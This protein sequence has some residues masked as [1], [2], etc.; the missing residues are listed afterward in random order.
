ALLDVA[1]VTRHPH[2]LLGEKLVVAWEDRLPIGWAHVREDQAGSLHARVGRVFDRELEVAVRRLSGRLQT[3][4]VAIVE[5]AV[6]EAAD[7]SI[8]DTTVSKRGAA[9][10]A[11][12]R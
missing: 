2:A 12:L 3:A 10:A 9:V 11:M 8:L 7:A 4:A 6:V 5:P 1:A